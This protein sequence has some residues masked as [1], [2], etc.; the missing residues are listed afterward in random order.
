MSNL[1]IAVPFTFT[2]HLPP[3]VMAQEAS[4]LHQSG[5]V[6]YVQLYD[7]VT[8]FFPRSLWTPANAPMAALLPD[9]DSVHDQFALAAYALAS[10][11]DAGLCLSTDAIRRGP[12]ELAQTLLSLAA[13]TNGR[14]MLQIGAGEVRQTSLG[15]WK[16]SQG[17]SRL[18]DQLR[19]WRALWDAQEPVSLEGNRWTLDDAFLGRQR[20]AHKPQIWTLGGGPRLIDL[21]TSYADGVN[22]AIPAVQA[23]PEIYGDWIDAL[24]A[25]L[26]QKD[27]DPAAFGFGGWAVMLIHED[28]DVL[29]R[30]LDNPLIRWV[31]A[32]WGRF[33]N[34]DWAKEQITPAFPV[35][36]HYSMKF[37]P[38]KISDSEA[39]DVIGRTTREM[40]EK[41]VLWGTP[42]QIAAKLAP[43]IDVG[44]NWLSL[45]DFLPI[46]LEPEDAAKGMGRV[47]ELAQRL[48]QY[49][50]ASAR[51]TVSARA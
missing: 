23:Y 1:E 50:P 40:A 36:W 8:G 34:A 38:M 46:V 48:K 18:E 49:Q 32:V 28:E 3:A 7:Q 2:R 41:C 39:Q 11:A 20:P 6:D 19:M 4:A 44:V 31:A 26:A 16:R 51:A 5:L 45:T 13:M 25:G 22:V 43:F 14:T 27:R 30:A 10:N 42:A 24:R 37:K 35:D 15:G 33:N 17:L 47:L 21:T 12:V 9:V 29:D